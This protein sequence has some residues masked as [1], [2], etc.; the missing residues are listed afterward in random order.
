MIEESIVGENRRREWLN[1]RN[2][3]SC[4]SSSFYEINLLI[5]L[6]IGASD[7]ARTGGLLHGKQTLYQL[8]YGCSTVVSKVFTHNTSL[9]WSIRPGSN[10]RSSAWQADASPT[11]LRMLYCFKTFNT[12]HETLK[13]IN[14]QVQ[15]KYFALKLCC[16]CVSASDGCSL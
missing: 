8:S 3:K 6:K 15:S 11:K 7:R 5:N 1:C 16:L 2:K 10:R 9:I 4:P 14:P 12:L 13:K